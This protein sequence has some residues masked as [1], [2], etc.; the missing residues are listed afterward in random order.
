MKLHSMRSFESIRRPL[1]L[2]LALLTLLLVQTAAHAQ[3]TCG[4]TITGKTVMTANLESCAADPALTLS[5]GAELDMQGF[6]INSCSGVGI[7]IMGDGAKLYNG[8]VDSCG[9]TGVDVNGNKNKVTSIVVIDSD[10]I[11]IIGSKNQVKNSFVRGSGVAYAIDGD[12]NHLKGNATQLAVLGYAVVGNGNKLSSNVAAEIDQDGVL[13]EGSG[14]KLQGNAAIESEVGFDIEGSNNTLKGNA[15]DLSIDTG[16]YIEQY[17][18][19]TSKVQNNSAVG[20]DASGFDVEGTLN[21]GEVKVSKNRATANGDEGFHVEL[22]V[23]ISKN[24]ASSNGGNG[25]LIGD[26]VATGNITLMNGI[27][28]RTQ[29]DGSVITKN[30]ALGN[31][32]NDLFAFSACLDDMF[33][34]NVFRTSNNPCIQ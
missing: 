22:H 12:A 7:R 13:V 2:S 20:N 8:V 5:A 14:N 34:A 33:S 23:A 30:I 6:R 29:G 3:V 32:M 15:A 27:G 16:F 17:S 26:S 1:P 19:G 18:N 4:Q 11:N 31:T 21:N 9:S 10:G 28:I 25:I 24:A